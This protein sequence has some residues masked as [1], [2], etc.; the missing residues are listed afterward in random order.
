MAG[1]RQHS[2]SIQEFEHFLGEL[3]DSTATHTNKHVIITGD[4]NATSTTWGGSGNTHYPGD[5]DWRNG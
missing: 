4:F 5:N 2:C 3:T 1:N